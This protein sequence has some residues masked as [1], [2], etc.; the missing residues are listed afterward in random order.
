MKKTMHKSRQDRMLLCPR[1]HI[2]GSGQAAFFDT[3]R[4]PMRRI[5]ACR[6]MK[7]LDRRTIEEMG[8][9]SCVLME[10]AAL[11]TVEVMEAFFE[12]EKSEQRILC[13]CGSGNNGET[14][15][16][17]PGS[18]FSTDTGRRSFWRENGE[19]HRGNRPSSST[20]RRNIMFR[21]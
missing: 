3:G 4:Y 13:V 12:R 6:E 8:V 9:P 21:L 10:R 20:L 15:W 18:F 16:R 17:S 5:V 2:Y 19:I 1:S 14:A 7:E 11:K